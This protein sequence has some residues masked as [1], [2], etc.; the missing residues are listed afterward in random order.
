MLL[1]HLGIKKP[2]VSYHEHNE[3]MRTAELAVRLAEGENI[4]LIYGC[5][6]AGVV[7]SGHASRA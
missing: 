5:R 1:K 6:N 7:R 3:A 4:A 2:F